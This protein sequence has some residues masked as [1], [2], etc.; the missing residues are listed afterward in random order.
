M[1]WP[2]DGIGSAHSLSSHFVTKRRSWKVP[3]PSFLVPAVLDSLRSPGSG[4]SHITRLVP[5]EADPFCA[6]AIRRDGGTL[7]TADSD[8]LL[9][10]LGPEGNIVFLDDLEM[11]SATWEP[12]GISALVYNQRA[13]LEKSAM[14]SDQ[15]A[16]LDFAF[17]LQMDPILPVSYYL[18]QPRT[19][20]STAPHADQYHTF[21]SQYLG[22][23]GLSDRNLDGCMDF[24]DPRISEL[25]LYATGGV[26]MD[27]L[28]PDAEPSPQSPAFYLPLLLDN[29]TLASAWCPSVSIRK[30]AYSL[31]Y[32]GER[33]KGTRPTAV[34]E[35]RRTLT[36]ESKGHEVELY[37]KSEIAGAIRDLAGYM[38]AFSRD[39]VLGF[40]KS[41]WVALCLGLHIY[42]AAEEGEKSLTIRIWRRAAKSKWRL[43]PHDWEVIHLCAQIQASLYSLRILQQVSKCYEAGVFDGEPTGEE[44]K[45]KIDDDKN[46][47]T[48][49]KKLLDQHLSSLPPIED[50]T[51][52]EEMVE[53]FADLRE[54]GLLEFLSLV[55]GMDEPTPLGVP[56]KIMRA[57]Q[58]AKKAK[59]QQQWA[60]QMG[61]S[62]SSSTSNPFDVL[63]SE[64]ES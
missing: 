24:L 42:H 60:E 53:L 13:I 6:D 22:D 29:W 52:T 34:V 47:L 48:A 4:Y 59:L 26:A 37:Q 18:S 19:Q 11:E 23:A 7:L 14:G 54:D 31:C 45:K 39:I 56:G 40:R 62:H 16:I 2:A 58:K 28:A 8:M 3:V 33:R 20:H 38:K 35:Y 27:K 49:N 15:Q 36:E 64:S 32:L 5:G 17:Q 25:V 57:E 21:T 10:D 51:S 44:K 43:D 41:Q 12:K 30:L 9:Y 63:K 46:E 1:E 61:G 50:I 55:I